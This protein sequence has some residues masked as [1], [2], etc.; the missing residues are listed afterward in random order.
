MQKRIEELETLIPQLEQQLD[1]IT[2]A[3]GAASVN[4]DAER[5]RS[6]GEAYTRAEAELHE[7]MSE[8]ERLVD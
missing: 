1:E 3:I 7:T 2:E 5:V 6:L 4:A 8:W